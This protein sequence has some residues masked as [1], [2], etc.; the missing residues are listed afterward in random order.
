MANFET[1]LSPSN[2]LL[3]GR[4]LGD[5]TFNFQAPPV[6]LPSPDKGEPPPRLGGNNF[7]QGQLA[8]PAGVPELAPKLARIYGFSYEGHYYDLPKPAIFL[9]HGDGVDAEG[10]F[11]GS[12]T[13]QRRVSRAPTNVDRTG[14]AG[15]TGSYAEDMKVWSY[16]KGDFSIRLDVETGPFD[17]ILLDAF[18]GQDALPSYFGGAQARIS[19]AQARISGAQAR[20]SG[21]QARGA[22]A[23][24]G[25]G[26]GGG[27]SD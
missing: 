18:L 3:Y 20:I 8:A 26:R 14:T 4:V 6:N 16:D 21:A 1:L 10:P 27:W 23:R 9:V 12:S 7:L 19:G 25:S 22:Q 24:I 11:P 13:A 15:Q 17:Q 2:I 5:V